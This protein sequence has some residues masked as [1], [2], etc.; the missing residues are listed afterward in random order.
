MPF[1]L[2]RIFKKRLENYDECAIVFF[3]ACIG[4]V[5][6]WETCTAMT[7]RFMSDEKTMKCSKRV[8]KGEGYGCFK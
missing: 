7:E 8:A 5:V 2:L 6:F 3:V 1:V 4:C